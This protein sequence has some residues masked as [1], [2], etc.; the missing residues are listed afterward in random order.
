MVEGKVY[1][2][3]EAQRR[4]SVPVRAGVHR[5]GPASPR[6]SRP[7]RRALPWIWRRPCVSCR[8]YRRGVDRLVVEAAQ[9]WGRCWPSKALLISCAPSTFR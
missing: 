3:V 7:R 2:D 6:T 9:F 8:G 5:V 1:E 4:A